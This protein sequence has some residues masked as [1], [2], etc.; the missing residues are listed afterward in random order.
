MYLYFDK[1]SLIK[2]KFY[3]FGYV[4]CVCSSVIIFCLLDSKSVFLYTSPL[5][6]LSSVFLFIPFLC[7]SFHS[8]II[9]WVAPSTFAVYIIQ[10]TFPYITLLK[11]TDIYLVENYSYMLYW[12]ISLGVL[13]LFFF[14]C[15]IYDKAISLLI[16]PMTVR[17]C[18]KL[19]KHHN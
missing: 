8:K 10:V 7:V 13:I 15:V 4:S 18:E 6:I 11:R 19:E 9:N 1:I 2:K 5:T 3:F 17:I 14:F 16:K 12:L